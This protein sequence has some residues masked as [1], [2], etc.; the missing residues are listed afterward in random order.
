MSA[1]PKVRDV[2]ERN[3]VITR[4]FD[5][6]RELVF[7][8]RTDPELL[9]EWW[10]P[11]QFSTPI[12]EMDVR[13]GGAYRIVLR[14]SDGIDYPVKGIYREVVPPKL[15][16][17][18]VDMSE[19]P[20]EWQD[21]LTKQLE[22]KDADISRLLCRVTFEEEGGKTRLTVRSTFP[23]TKVRDAFLR[24]GMETGWSE[25]LAK[26]AMLLGKA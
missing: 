9:T 26:L 22:G 6:P 11:A 17:Y 3:F 16:V 13:P 15:L 4:V 12:R 7:K 5:A 2:E 8:A 20:A 21:L 23:S 1:S 14:S 10:G 19:H 25:M 18:T 24:M